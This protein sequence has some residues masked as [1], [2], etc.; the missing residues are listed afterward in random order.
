MVV[1]LLGVSYSTSLAEVIYVDV[2]A[3]GANDGTNWANAYNL[4]R[5][6]LDAAGGGDEIWVASGTYYPTAKV[7][8]TSERYKTF[9]MK[10]G[11]GIYGGFDGTETAVDQRDV[12]NNETILSGD[13][14]AP[15]NNSDNCYHVFY[16]FYGYSAGL[17]T[18]ATLDGFTITGGNAD[19]YYSPY[20][21]GGGMINYSSSPTVTNCT[22][23]GNSAEDEGGGMYNDSSLTVTTNCTFS[24][25]SASFGG[26]MYN[27]YSSNPAVIGCTFIGNKWITL[28]YKESGYTIMANCIFWDNIGGAIAY[29]PPPPQPL[30]GSPLESR[31]NISSGVTYSN[32][33]GGWP[34]EGNIDMDPLF[35]DAASGNYHLR[36]GSPCIDAGTDAGVYEDIE[37]NVRPW[38]YPGVDNNDPDEPEFDMG[39]Y[40]FVNISPV[41]D[42]GPD[43]TVY[44]GAKSVAEVTLDGSGSYDSDG[45]A[46]TYKWNWEVEGEVFTSTGGDAL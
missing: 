7:G 14:G 44:A 39:A 29:L 18:T 42:A 20:Y 33:Q 6:G 46:L 28:I 1:F 36:R 45:D 34:G 21:S 10:N 41:A 15:G 35:V 5:D 23:T 22:F 24:G 4:L 32:V 25:N 40:E 17:D 31:G 19:H 37:G 12:E 2:G 26:G 16:H 30:V 9:Q 27:N 38:D 11:V 13:I 3:G 43:Q 8:G